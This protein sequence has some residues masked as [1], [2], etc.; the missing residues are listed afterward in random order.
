MH[1]WFYTS[2]MALSCEGTVAR[3]GIQ[4]SH[5]MGNCWRV[6][7]SGHRFLEAFCVEGGRDVYPPLRVA[8]KCPCGG[9]VWPHE[10]SLS[11]SFLLPS[12]GPGL[13]AP[14][15]G[16]QP[17]GSLPL[18]ARESG[19]TGCFQLRLGCSLPS[20]AAA[21]GALLH[22]SLG[23]QE[24]LL[25][26]PPQVRGLEGSEISG[27]PACWLRGWLSEGRLPRRLWMQEKTPPQS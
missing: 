1:L 4:N 24:L 15:A 5:N 14:V 22:L 23:D 13:P 11:L 12:L 21:D 10:P 16:A 6:W 18:P 26:P 20:C 7:A 27:N 17:Q 19:P 9:Q 3:E 8:I 25:H 2:G